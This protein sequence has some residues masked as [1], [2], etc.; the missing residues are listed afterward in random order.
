MNHYNLF[1]QLKKDC[2]V[3]DIETW[4]QIYPEHTEALM[5]ILKEL[6]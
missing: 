2:L 6:K 1:N 3:I 5:K 4:A